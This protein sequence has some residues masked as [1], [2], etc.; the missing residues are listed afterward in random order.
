MCNDRLDKEIKLIR[1][2][3]IVL[4]F[5]SSKRILDDIEKCKT[6]IDNYTNDLLDDDCLEIVFIKLRLEKEY[7]RRDKKE[8]KNG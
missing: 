8:S 6:Y 2:Y 1:K 5:W 3:P 7:S 4:R